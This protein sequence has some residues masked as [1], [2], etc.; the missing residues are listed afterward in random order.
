[1]K[2]W[3][4]PVIHVIT[5]A[6]RVIVWN[7]NME[8]IIISLFRPSCYNI[9]YRCYNHGNTLK[10]HVQTHG[11]LLKIINNA[12]TQNSQNLSCSEWPTESY[13]TTFAI[14]RVSWTIIS[15]HLFLSQENASGQEGDDTI[16]EAT[17]TKGA[18]YRYLYP[19]YYFIWPPNDTVRGFDSWFKMAPQFRYVIKILTVVLRKIG[20]ISFHGA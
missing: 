10:S 6:V 11:N 4:L 20:L 7:T 17:Q 1:M 9:Q 15:N 5:C 3:V 16:D 12:K 2:R 13:Y 18:W 19:F 14:C 8:N